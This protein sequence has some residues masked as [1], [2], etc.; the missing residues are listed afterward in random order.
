MLES[1]KDD[2]LFA[3]IDGY[4]VFE[5]KGKREIKGWRLFRTG[6]HCS[7]NRRGTVLFKTHF[8]Q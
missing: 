6:I 3:L 8:T 5:R 1:V 4:V 2:T 7:L